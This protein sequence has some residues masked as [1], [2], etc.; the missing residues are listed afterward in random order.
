MCVVVVVVVI[1]V[2]VVVVAIAN[3]LNVENSKCFGK[4]KTFHSLLIC[5]QILC[6]SDSPVYTLL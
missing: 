6:S 1:I 2:E 5:W 3:D 4:T